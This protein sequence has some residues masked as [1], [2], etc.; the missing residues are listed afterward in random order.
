M[1]GT[2]D[3]EDLFT[4]LYQNKTFPRVAPLPAKGGSE[5]KD[6]GITLGKPL[7]TFIHKPSLVH[8]TKTG[9][10]ITLHP[11]LSRHQKSFMKTSA[12]KGYQTA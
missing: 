12:Q 3:N 2:K 9:Q 10:I 7:L 8:V 4:R 5:G 11:P 1:M 6:R